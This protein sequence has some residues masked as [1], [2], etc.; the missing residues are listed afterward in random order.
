MAVLIQRKNSLYADD[1]EPENENFVYYY[2][3]ELLEKAKKEHQAS[4]KVLCVLFVAEKEDSQKAVHAMEVLA[5][6]K[7]PN[8]IFA[9][10]RWDKKKFAKE[11]SD[12]TFSGIKMKEVTTW[13]I[14]RNNKRYQVR[15]DPKKA[16]M[17]AELSDWM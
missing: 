4:G 16:A 14:F 9:V 13:N 12:F 5:K 3:P 17:A 15:F 1:F 11:W 8:Q 10:A 6:K 2:K 7:N